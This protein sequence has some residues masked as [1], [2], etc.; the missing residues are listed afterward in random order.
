MKNAVLFI[1]FLLSAVSA[2]GQGVPYAQ[3]L[4]AE[5][6]SAIESMGDYRADFTY[7]VGGETEPRKCVLY[8]RGDKY[9]LETDLFTVLSDGKYVYAITDD[10]KEVSVH[11]VKEA[12]Q[13]MG[14]APVQVI[15]KKFSETFTPRTDRLEGAVQ[16]LRLLPKDGNSPTSHIRVGIDTTTKLPVYIE[17]VS[18]N[19]ARTELKIAVILRGKGADE[20]LYRFDDAKYKKMGYYIARP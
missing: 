5:S 13:S 20:T 8:A 14:F 17:E 10:E 2:A 11:D 19:G 6:I 4:M 18:V 9:R 1:S 12:G 16:Y 15:L 7:T 3:R